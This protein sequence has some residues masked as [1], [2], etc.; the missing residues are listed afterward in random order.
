MVVD[1]QGGVVLL[2]LKQILGLI[3]INLIFKQGLLLIHTKKRQVLRNIHQI[4][5]IIRFFNYS[6]KP[7]FAIFA[8]ILFHSLRLRPSLFNLFIIIN[9]FFTRWC[10]RIIQAIFLI[11]IHL[12]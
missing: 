3:L 7:F 2:P 12:F 10:F 5:P 1:L 6:L 8:F 11:Q 9:L 4:H